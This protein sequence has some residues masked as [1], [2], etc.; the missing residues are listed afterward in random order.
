M[1]TTTAAASVTTPADVTTHVTD[2][3]S[4]NGAVTSSAAAPASPLERLDNLIKVKIFKS[5]H[6]AVMLA[7]INV[8]Y[9]R[10]FDEHS[11]AILQFGTHLLTRNVRL[12]V[13]PVLSLE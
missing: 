12:S 6:L 4:Q 8:T 5:E 3:T 9:E 2:V 11:F 1:S 7:N 13:K 10:L